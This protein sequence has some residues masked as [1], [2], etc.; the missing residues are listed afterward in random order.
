MAA[1]L[2]SDFG[3][4]TSHEGTHVYAGVDL[5]SERDKKLNKFLRD[6][7]DRFPGYK[8]R[9]FNRKPRHPPTCPS[10]HET[11]AKCPHCGNAVRGTMEKGVDV[12]IVTDMFQHAWDNT[13]DIAVLLSNDADFIPAAEFL[14]TRGKRIIHAGFGH[15]GADLAKACWGHIG[16]DRMKTELD[17]ANTS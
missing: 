11:I 6:T 1:R 9:I 3:I 10:C 5:S 2:S 16:L 7:L 4:E 12:S 14:N 8:V 13:Y 15:Q 17:N